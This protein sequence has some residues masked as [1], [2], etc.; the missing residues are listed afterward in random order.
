MKP[1]RILLGILAGLS[2]QAASARAQRDLPYLEPRG[3]AVQLIVD[4]APYLALAGELH[5]SSPSSPAYMAPIWDRLAKNNVK[6][7][8]GAASWELVE[9]EEGRYDFTAVDDQIKQARARGI[10]L[11]MIWFGAYKN[12][13]S[14]YAPSWVRRDETRF[15]RAARTGSNAMGAFFTTMLSAFN[16]RLAEADAR[17]FAALMRHIKKVDRDQTI[18]MMQVENEVGLLGDSRDRSAQANAAWSQQVPAELMAYLRTHRNMLKPSLVELWGRQGF[19]ETGSWAEVFGSDPLAEEVFMAW[20]FGRYVDRVAK[21]GAAEYAL[22]MFAN[23]WLGPQPGALVPGQYPSGGPVARMMDVWKAAAPSLA[24]L[25]P[26]I[27]VKEFD[28]TL[29]LYRRADNPIF[30]P[31]AKLDAGNLFIALGKHAAIGFS[32]FG[33]ED[34]PD[35]HDVFNAYRTLNGMTGPIA[36]AQAEGRIRGF[37]LPVGGKWE[38]RLGGYDISITG[39]G[40]T[41]GAFGAGTGAEAVKTSGYGLII[42]QSDDEYLVVGRGIAIKFA[43]PDREV[44]ID[45]AQE[46]TFENGRWIAGRTLNGDERYALFPTDDL[47]IVRMK[48]LRRRL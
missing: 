31:E 20:G 24:L 47:R 11:V 37:K 34:A 5:N 46:G 23:A 36:R 48:L 40:S 6:T 26:D 17:A 35:G 3:E 44:E 38:E 32:P 15:P 42:Q 8:I 13:E 33:I 16:D 25:A 19:R 12:A 4:G 45:S 43:A 29:A 22:P 30:V 1:G 10:R 41:L 2:L 27:Y 21:A 9:P 28:E 39:P 14:K 18:I 7:V